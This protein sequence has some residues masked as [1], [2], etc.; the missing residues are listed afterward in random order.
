MPTSRNEFFHAPYNA[1][2]QTDLDPMGMRGGFR[3]DILDDP[4]RQFSGSLVLFLYNHDACSRFDMGPDFSVHWQIP[5]EEVI[6][7]SSL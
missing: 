5:E 7:R 6:T 4:L 2:F 1:A 3:E